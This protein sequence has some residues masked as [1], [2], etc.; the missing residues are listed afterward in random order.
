[1]VKELYKDQM[2]R[3]VTLAKMPKRIVSLVPSQTELLVDLGLEDQ[4]VGLTKFCVRPKGLKEKKTII[5]GTKQFKFEVIKALEPDLIIGNKEENYREGI[6][7]LEQRFPVWMSDIYNLSDAFKMISDIG[8]LTGKEGE[9][10]KLIGKIQ[11]DWLKRVARIGTV[12]YLIWQEP[13]IGVG[14]KTFIDEM[15][16][17]NGLENV[18]ESER[19]PSLKIEEIEDLNPDFIFLSSEP[20]PFKETHL[21]VFQKLFPHSKVVLVDGEMFSWYG[22]RLQYAPAYFKSLSKRLV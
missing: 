12:L 7:I 11:Q 5:G 17:W 2:G 14:K 8:A 15:L 20:F 10:Q 1:M 6:E 9:A 13:I 18:L 3:E 16:K 19:Y 4:L 22:S 21:D